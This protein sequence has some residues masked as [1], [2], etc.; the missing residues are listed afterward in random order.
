[1][2][3]DRAVDA[4]GDRPV[5]ALPE[6][7]AGGGAH[8]A[9]LP[10]RDGGAG[11]AIGDGN[12]MRKLLDRNCHLRDQPGHLGEPGQLQHSRRR[13]SVLDRCKQAPLTGVV[14]LLLM[15]GVTG[16]SAGQE[17][18]SELRVFGS[19]SLATGEPCNGCALAFSS[20]DYM[21]P[22]IG[23]GIGKDGTFSWSA[24]GPGEFWVEAAN[25]DGRAV[26]TVTLVDEDV[27]V[28]LTLE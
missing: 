18:S 7:P 3:G 26:E 6:P 4:A 13:V 2:G 12:S 8:H 16:C 20:P 10:V 28:S 17:P 23:F 25:P 21:I 15:V 27:E 19:V 14:A 22:E 11:L 5:P 24:P 9:P 1:M